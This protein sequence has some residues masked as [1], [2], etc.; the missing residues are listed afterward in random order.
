MLD[1]SAEIRWD[2]QINNKII[3]SL[4]YF[5]FTFYSFSELKVLRR[6]MNL[7]STWVNALLIC[8]DKA[9]EG[10]VVLLLAVY[11]R[12]LHTMFIIVVHQ[13]IQNTVSI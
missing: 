12:R 13:Q 4:S 7:Y 8:R 10:K 1:R 6:L 11:K 9:Y 5:C 2:K 3:H